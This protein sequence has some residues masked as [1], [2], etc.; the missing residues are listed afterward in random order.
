VREEVLA[1]DDAENVYSGVPT[2][3]ARL[4]F[5]ENLTGKLFSILTAVNQNGGSFV[6]LIIADML[7]SLVPAQ[8]GI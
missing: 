6:I 2:T 3:T 8:E 5:N 1:G 4:V 7:H